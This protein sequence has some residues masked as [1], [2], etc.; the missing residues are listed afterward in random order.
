L[1]DQHRF[2][3][4]FGSFNPVHQGHLIIGEFMATQTDLTHVQFVVSPQ[5]PLKRPEELAP[6]DHRLKMTR[7]AVRGNPLLTVNP[8]EFNLPRPSYTIDTLRMLQ[9]RKPGA[10]HH[11]IIGSDNLAIIEKWREWEAIV[12]DFGCYVYIRPGHSPGQRSDL[13]GVHILDTP[14][15]DIS[16]TRIRAYVRAGHSIRYMV[17]E[18]VRRYIADYQL[19]E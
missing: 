3:Y 1:A 9:K 10:T 6:E 8:I 19:Y 15:L 16:S 18:N 11:L 2:G 14:L 4:L 7:L 13:H 12:R 17:P 5:N